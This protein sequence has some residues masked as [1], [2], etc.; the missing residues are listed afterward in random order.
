M[1]YSKLFISILFLAL[2]VT[3][4]SSHSVLLAKNKSTSTLPV[5]E[6]VNHENKNL[7]LRGD[8][9]FAFAAMGAISTYLTF[10]RK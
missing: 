10:K 9:W 1:K 4:A 2:A 8:V 3:V 7:P 5:K 6:K